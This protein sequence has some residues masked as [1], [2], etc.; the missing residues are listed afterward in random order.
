MIDINGI[1]EK[2]KEYVAKHPEL[3]QK[4][5]TSHCNMYGY[6]FSGDAR[7]ILRI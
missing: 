7:R 6:A 1:I 2:N 5:L 3:A 4:G